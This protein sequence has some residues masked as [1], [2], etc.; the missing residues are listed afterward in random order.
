MKLDKQLIYFNAILGGLGGLF[1]WIAMTML[2]SII[3]IP[4]SGG[5]IFVA[6]GFRGFLVGIC[7]GAAVGSTDGIVTNRSL[8]RLAQGARYGAALGA[9][10]GVVGLVLGEVLFQVL[11]GGIWARAVGWA[12]FGLLVG[13][14]DGVARK[15]PSRIRYGLLGGLL[16]GLIGGSTYERLTLI[17]LG[18][19]GMRS[20]ALA[21][22]SAVGLIMLGACIGAFVG[23]VES[24]LRRAWL[25]FLNGRLEGQH[26]T[27]DPK[28][29]LTTLGSSDQCVIVLLGDR[30]VAGIHAEIT[31]QSSEF[32]LRP[33]EGTVTVER[34]N[35]VISVVNHS[36]RSGDRIQLGATRMVFH[37]EELQAR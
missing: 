20:Y 33:R 5:W 22:G 11:S 26:R 2:A 6:D 15:M 10:G 12:T 30:K 34:G 8:R 23:L 14:S 19:S 9:L 35:E 1:G 25:T 31:A 27:L 21:W 32:V 3:T 37:D 28:Q 36:L 4:T 18:V 17:L 7:I 13:T 16:G 24:V 29:P